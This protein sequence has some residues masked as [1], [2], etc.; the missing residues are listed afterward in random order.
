MCI[1]SPGVLFLVEEV[2]ALA[3]ARWVDEATGWGSK[4][5]P[6]QKE[7]LPETQQADVALIMQPV[8]CDMA[9]GATAAQA[10]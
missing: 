4:T 2:A 7:S 5:V 1:F 9:G 10:E 6:C 3:V 8:L